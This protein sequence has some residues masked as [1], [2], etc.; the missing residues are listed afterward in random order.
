MMEG[1]QLLI[2]REIDKQE[3]PIICKKILLHTGKPKGV[4]QHLT[5]IKT[6]LSLM[7]TLSPYTKIFKK[8]F[9]TNIRNKMKNKLKYM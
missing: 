3:A 2:K 5:F 4:Y 1:K 8:N 6:N 9:K 7:K